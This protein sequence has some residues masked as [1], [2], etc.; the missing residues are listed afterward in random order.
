[1]RFLWLTSRCQLGVR[2]MRRPLR[3]RRPRLPGCARLGEGA[4]GRDSNASRGPARGTRHAGRGSS[5][6]LAGTGPLKRQVSSA[7]AGWTGASPWTEAGSNGQATALW[8]PAPA[9]TV[10][11]RRV[12]APAR[13]FSS[14]WRALGKGSVVR[15]RPLVGTGAAR[16]RRA[17]PP[18]WQCYLLVDPIQEVGILDQVAHTQVFLLHPPPRV[19][20]KLVGVGA[21]LQEAPDCR[22][23]SP[24]V[25][26]V[27]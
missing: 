10:T 21:V 19:L 24:G 20:A 7:C 25:G 27:L 15:V 4:L 23:E 6:R 11:L 9:E 12:S 5:G 22:P 1:M 16:R 14:P 3:F 8:P 26:R 13:R 17:P 2:E 18:T